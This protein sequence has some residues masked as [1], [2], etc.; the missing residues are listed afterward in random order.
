L[1]KY[2]L[3]WKKLIFLEFSERQLYA[4][5]RNHLTAFGADYYKRAYDNDQLPISNIILKIIRGKCPYE[6]LS[7]ALQLNQAKGNTQILTTLLML[8]RRQLQ[9]P[10]ASGLIPRLRKTKNCLK[11]NSDEISNRK[12]R[13]I[14]TYC[15]VNG[16][17]DT[18]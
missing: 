2:L 4:K 10:M 5:I 7:D 8:Q 12:L 11:K 17:Q 14:K 9:L 3:I 15:V 1:Y 6:L 13:I 16:A 18:R